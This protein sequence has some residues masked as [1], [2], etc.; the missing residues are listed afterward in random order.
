VAA[1]LAAHRAER[2]DLEL[3]FVHRALQA[4]RSDGAVRDKLAPLW[5]P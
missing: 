3:Q 1:A 4:G 5:G 2:S